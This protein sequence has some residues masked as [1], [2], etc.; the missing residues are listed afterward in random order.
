MTG[1]IILPQRQTAL[2]AKQAAEVDVLSGGRL[3]LGIGIGWNSVEYE[4]LGMDFRNRGIRVSEQV[5]LLRALWTQEIV[6]FRGRWHTVNEAGLGFLPVQRPIPIWMGGSADVVFR[7]VAKFADGW[8]FG[9]GATN[10]FARPKARTPQELVGVLRREVQ[11]A[12]RDP[13]AV[14]IEARISLASGT[15]DD[16]RRAVEEWRGLGA[17]HLSVATMRAGFKTVHAHIEKARQFLSAAEGA[18]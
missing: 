2:V 9:G 17:T 3:R 18:A 4:A 11:A 1:I 14:G 10:P 15:P 16:W 7:R 5:K 8:I 6:T 12:G 13:A